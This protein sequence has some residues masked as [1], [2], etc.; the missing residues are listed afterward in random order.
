[1][2]KQAP[3]ILYNASAGSGKTFTLVKYYLKLLL[4]ATFNDAYTSILA[5]T[6]TNK[7]VGEMKVRIINTLKEFAQ[8]NSLENESAMFSSIK[9][10]TGLS[11]LQVHQKSKAILRSI[12]YNY[13]A[14]DIS[15]IDGFT[16]KII[17]TFAYDLQLPINFEVALD[18]DVLLQKAVDNLLA[19]TGIDKEITSILIDFALEKADDDKS[20]DISFDFNKI[21]KLL[22]NEND[23][24]YLKKLEH[25]TLADFS[26]IKKQLQ[27]NSTIAEKKLIETATAALTL[28]AD[29]G[30][31]FSNFSGGSRAYVPNYFL[32]LQQLNFTVNF[33]SAWATSIEDKPLYAAKTENFIKSTLDTI[34]PEI[35]RYFNA[36]K[37]LFFEIKFLKACAKNITPLSVLH[38]ISKELESIKTENNLLLISEFNSIISNEI[39]NQPTPFIYER[40][41]EKFA[42]Y[43]IDEFQDTSTLQWQNLI[44][45]LEHSLSSENLKEEQGT[46][47]LVGDAKQ[48]IYRWRGGEAEQFINLCT[49]TNPFHVPK[50]VETLTT[51]FRSY[52]EIIHFNNS[53]FSFISKTVFSNPAYSNLYASG[54]KQKTHL[55]KTG[56]VA[57]DFLPITP[58]DKDIVY[59]EKVVTYITN[60]IANGYS[61]SEI[62]ILVRKRKEGVAIAT[63]ITENTT[64]P[65][66]S[67]ETM[68]LHS[69]AEVRF[70]HSFLKLVI[71]PNNKTEKLKVL[72]YLAKTNSITDTHHFLHTLINLNLHQICES[73]KNYGYQ[74]PSRNLVEL[75][76]YDA[77]ETLIRCCKLD[78]ETN[79]YLQFYLDIVLEFSEKET[80]SFIDFINYFDENETKF[81]IT[82]PSGFNTVQI[83]TIHKS[84]GLEFPVVIFPYAELNIYKE[85]D[86]KVWFPLNAER[87]NGF[88]F[89]L[90]NYNADLEYFGETGNAIYH[91]HQSELELDAINLL[92]VALTRA[93]EQLYI[94]SKKPKNKKPITKINTY[95]DILITYLIEQKVWNYETDTYTF[96]TV[97]KESEAISN[98]SEMETQTQF[99][100]TSKTSHNLKI[101]TNSGLL[102][103]TKQAQA[104]EKGNLL[105]AM[106]S[107][108]YTFN[109]TSNV[110]SNYYKKGI[111]DQLQKEELKSTLEAIVLHPN[112]KP[113]FT[114]NYTIYNEHDIFL[115][116][117]KTIRP[118]RFVVNQNN[119]TIIIDYKTGKEEVSHIQQIKHYAE[120]L[121]T[122]NYNVQKKLLVYTN[123]EIKIKTV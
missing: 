40:L 17:R 14:F 115:P 9:N 29:S 47:L 94:L 92:Y 97:K 100:S 118:D 70:V 86:A 6:F 96:G 120:I 49:T 35:I 90:L 8:P 111:I 62:C 21:A 33:K 11:A 2:Q 56:Y 76:L 24:F 46:A 66:T 87:F 28:I 74:I 73:L 93:K 20:W 107:E 81:S 7:A 25:K 121:T 30:L 19:K 89:T 10:E 13:A 65:I 108:I 103:N 39:K 42:H 51:N 77:I 72:H 22:V 50:K 83:M 15:T 23:I 16:H 113:Y 123:Q 27:K 45:L 91:Q 31:E 1:M 64:I 106:L 5:I 61:Y 117:T 88:S 26:T 3:F 109:D 110:V 71:N 112:L 58:L 98:S 99:I 34:Q 104:I 41:G 60:C 67:S 36:T 69:N 75:P 102:W 59:P 57:V 18:Q 52:S 68:L 54:S 37:T 78:T 114:T 80:T 85:I 43:C 38:A 44:P 95:A 48:A 82:T 79:A 32:K 55:E 4:L 122:L 12:L 63:Y 116:N 84:K 53:L 105:H 119:E 101:I